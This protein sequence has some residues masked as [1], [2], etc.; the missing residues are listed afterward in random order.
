M[1][2]WL[3]VESHILLFKIKKKFLELKFLERKIST[4]SSP[5][6][7][8]EGSKR[9]IIFLTN[10]TKLYIPNALYKIQKKFI[11]FKTTTEMDIILGF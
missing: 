8:I 5:T 11:K 4:I 6:D 9:A 3:I 10:W 1:Y 2:A 7:S